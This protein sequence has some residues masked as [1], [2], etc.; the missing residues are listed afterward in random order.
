M[1][2]S[3]IYGLVAP[4]K[5]NDNH[6]DDSYFGADWSTR[7][8]DSNVARELRP[9]LGAIETFVYAGFVQVEPSDQEKET[10]WN[11][12]DKW[13]KSSS[14]NQQDLDKIRETLPL[15][16][17]ESRFASRISETINTLEG[18]EYLIK[19]PSVKPGKLPKAP[20][21]EDA[22]PLQPRTIPT[23]P[24]ASVPSGATSSAAG[25]ASAA[26]QA[27]SYV[28]LTVTPAPASGPDNGKRVQHAGVEWKEAYLNSPEAAELKKILLDIDQFV[29][30][31]DSNVSGAAPKLKGPKEKEINE[32]ERKLKEWA[33]G[34]GYRENGIFAIVRIVEGLSQIKGANPNARRAKIAIDLLVEGETSIVRSFKSN[35]EI[36][37]KAVW[38]QE[39]LDKNPKAKTALQALD[40]AIADL[41]PESEK[42]LKE[43]LNAFVESEEFKN[44]QD[45]ARHALVL[46]MLGSHLGK[47]IG[48]MP[49]YPGK[50][51]RFHQKRFI[52][53]QQVFV[54]RL[55][56]P[57][58]NKTKVHL[59]T[60]SMRADIST[61]KAQDAIHYMTFGIVPKAL[62]P[63]TTDGG[64]TA[65][66]SMVIQTP[67]LKPGNFEPIIR[68]QQ[69]FGFTGTGKNTAH[70]N[71]GS[72]QFGLA[73][74]ET[75]P[76]GYGRVGRGEGFHLFLLSQP[77][78]TIGPGWVNVAGIEGS[79][80]T[81]VVAADTMFKGVM[82]TSAPLIDVG[83]HGVGVTA[84]FVT[85]NTNLFKGGLGPEPSYMYTGV[86]V[87]VSYTDFAKGTNKSTDSNQYLYRRPTW[88]GL[89][90]SFYNH[91]LAMVVA[92]VYN[93]EGA[94]YMLN[95]PQVAT[96]VEGV[97][98][99][100]SPFQAL[101]AINLGFATLGVARTAGP[102]RDAAQY[103]SP[104]QRA[105]AMAVPVAE[106]ALAWGG[107]GAMGQDEDTTTL[108]TQ[109]D[110]IREGRLWNAT[111]A[112]NNAVYVLAGGLGLF[113]NA[114]YS[115]TQAFKK[116]RPWHNFKIAWPYVSNLALGL[117]GFGMFAFA[118]LHNVK[119]A[120]IPGPPDDG[121]GT[122]TVVNT[123]KPTNEAALINDADGYTG[124]VQRPR[125][126]LTQGGL[127]FAIVGFG[128]VAQ[129]ALRSG[130]Y[131]K[132][133]RL[134]FAPIFSPT[135]K[136]VNLKFR[137]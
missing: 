13:M 96:D 52:E 86:S 25:A 91:S 35:Y 3:S 36:Y 81:G 132:A 37:L 40:Y 110:T 77:R 38:P 130:R 101:T 121:I 44:P 73:P 122:Y 64:L 10:L 135:T 137:F 92:N 32:F 70:Y 117:T 115:I 63:G 107:Y 17:G 4:A 1:T 27:S 74:T 94:T 54:D 24:S 106:T 108:A 9:V 2:I 61:A 82:S 84:S 71:S 128:A 66:A 131:K 125:E 20:K 41:D 43:A 8:K 51:E 29:F 47:Y 58:D 97:T 60:V 46:Q 105:V 124:E 109:R 119:N 30:G 14:F 79:E 123:A 11:S 76:F 87:G 15:I 103:G 16:A 18:L 100:W 85:R 113:G 48:L 98:S 93:H 49:T 78:M 57:E 6:G 80:E 69:V 45:T 104:A 62:Y 89:L 118:G 120:Y 33:R 22:I 136:A 95:L 88:T 34:E 75:N 26:T 42:N 127:F 102:V 83:Y 114:N 50:T 39:F 126:L 65:D 28:P 133:N 72:I 21:L 12:I 23:A 53:L 116:G 68:Y 90:S 67:K 56:K 112:T 129:L 111:L 55:R 5:G 99:Q 134:E 7:L 19:N 31:K 59:G